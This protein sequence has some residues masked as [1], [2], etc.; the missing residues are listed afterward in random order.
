MSDADEQLRARFKQAAKDSLR[1]ADSASKKAQ[2]QLYGLYRQATAGD[3]IGDRPG[4]LQFAD[5]AKYDA[6]AR[7]RGMLKP[8]AMAGFI[9]QVETLKA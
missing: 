5:R 8:A 9:A 7:N 2:L 6:W 4:L 3:V 1:L